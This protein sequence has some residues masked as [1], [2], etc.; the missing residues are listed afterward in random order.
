MTVADYLDTDVTRHKRELHYGIVREPAAPVYSHQSLLLRIARLLCDHV[1]PRGLGCVAI[2][3]VDVILDVDKALVLQPD[4]LFISEARR[5]IIKNQ[6]WGA[7]D[8]VVEIV[9]SSSSAFDRGQKLH[10]YAEYGVREYWLVDAP[11]EVVVIDFSAKPPKQ[12]IVTDEE[13]IPSVVLP[14]LALTASRILELHRRV[15]FD[16]L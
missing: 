6:V 2:A 7:P 15:R 4:L 12:Q 16:G 13:T 9:S 11:H 3:P 5:S 14:D 8:L 10:W 1:E